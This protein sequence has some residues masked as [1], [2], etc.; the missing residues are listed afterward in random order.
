MTEPDT[1]SEEAARSS[2]WVWRGAVLYGVFL[3]ALT[4]MVAGVWIIWTT[5]ELSAFPMALIAFGPIA[6]VSLFVVMMPPLKNSSLRR[7]LR[8]G[9]DQ[10]EE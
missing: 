2:R 1:R 6:V 8:K 9:E 3:L 5:G 10:E 7:R 4:P